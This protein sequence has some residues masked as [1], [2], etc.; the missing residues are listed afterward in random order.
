MRRLWRHAGVKNGPKSGIWKAL[1]LLIES[2][3]VYCLLW[4]LVVV[5]AFTSTFGHL[6]IK[7]RAPGWYQ[8][9]FYLTNGCLIA[10]VVSRSSVWPGDMKG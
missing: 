10:F 1:M 5:Y 4:V 6:S 2:G 9:G 7:T 3:S 8:L